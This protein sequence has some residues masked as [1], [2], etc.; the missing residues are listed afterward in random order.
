MKFS[1]SHFPLCSLCLRGQGFLVLPRLLASPPP[2][3]LA[4]PSSRPLGRGNPSHNHHRLRP[5]R[6][7]PRPQ[8]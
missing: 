6:R 3:F 2:H 7:N 5:N 8:P 1:L 4:F